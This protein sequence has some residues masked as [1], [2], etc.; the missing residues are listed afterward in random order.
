MWS[1]SGV[2]G[3]CVGGT[4]LDQDNLIG[5]VGGRNVGAAIK[6]CHSA[7]LVVGDAL[8]GWTCGRG[9][10]DTRYPGVSKRTSS[11]SKCSVV[12]LTRYDFNRRL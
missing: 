7:W 6:Q 3:L 2:G 12:A 5:M 11:K 9:S 1:S 8:I 4:N 10:S